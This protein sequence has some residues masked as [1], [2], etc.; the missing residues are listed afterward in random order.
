MGT[1]S[2]KSIA[3]S[4]IVNNSVT[5]VMMKSSSQCKMN[6]EAIQKMSFSDLDFVGC[7]VNFSNISQMADI[8]T[9][10]ACAQDTEQNT[11]LIN[12]FSTEL[13]QELEAALSGLPG[14]VISESETKSI[15]KMKNDIVAN[16]DIEQISECVASTLTEQKLEFDKIKVDCTGAEDTTVNFDNIK[17]RLIQSNVAECI[18]ANTQVTKSINDI[19]N[20]IDN[21]QKSYNTG[22]GLG[23]AGAAFL[24][25]VLIVFFVLSRF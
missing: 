23:I 1:A 19:Q 17:Q 14:A 5:N 16:I 13:D 21:K 22:I 20:T 6:T 2:S 24:V 3:I 15:T 11:E 4:D 10:F 9:N 25:I 8:E 18:Q 12:E 7:S